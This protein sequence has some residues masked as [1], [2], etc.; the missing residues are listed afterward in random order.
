MLHQVVRTESTPP[1]W[2]ALAWTV[3]RAGISIHDVRLLSVVFDGLVVAAIVVLASRIVGFTLALTAGGVAAVTAQLSAHGRELRAYE[4]LALLAL[5]LAVCL[6]RATER[7]SASRLALLA[8]TV[9]AGLLT[10][11]FFAFTIAAAVIWIVLEQQA[12]PVRRR[13]LAAVGVGCCVAVPWAPWFLEQYRADHYSWIGPFSATTVLATPLRILQ[14][15]LGSH[16]VEGLLLAW[17]AVAAFIGARAGARARM[18]VALALVPILLAA[19]TWAM[20]VRVYA[21]RNLIGTS[22]FIIVL[23]LVPLARLR[24]RV[25]LAAATG[26]VTILVGA[27]A[28]DQLRPSVPYQGLASALVADGWKSSSPVAVVDGPHTFTSPLEWYLPGAPDFAP[29]SRPA[30]GESQVFAVLGRRSPARSAIRDTIDVHGWLVGKLP[31]SELGKART[32][33]TLL[34]PAGKTLVAP[35]RTAAPRSAS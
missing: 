27:Y 24:P 28:V 25:S 16:A 1:L 20:G 14:P 21:V 19:V 17:L 6:D 3:H 33:L 31:A 18:I 8:G 5:A 15:M 26:L 2:Y 23:L 22:P 10:H 32:Q 11:Y 12:R 13:L 34:V 35:Q 9:T 7:P 4:L 29:R 30:A